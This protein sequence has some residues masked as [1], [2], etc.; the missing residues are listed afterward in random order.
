MTERYAWEYHLTYLKRLLAN[1]CTS[2]AGPVH[3]KTS[4]DGSLTVR[5]RL[6]PRKSTR[7]GI[8]RAMV[9]YVWNVELRW[10]NAR[11]APGNRWQLRRRRRCRA[12]VRQQR[13]TYDSGFCRTGANACLR[14]GPVQ[15]PFTAE[16]SEIIGENDAQGPATGRRRRRNARRVNKGKHRN[17]NHA[18]GFRK[19]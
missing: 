13:K 11:A 2:L 9:V 5:V 1:G 18:S 15:R 12:D 16:R 7:R 14:R 6:R 17:N 4:E 10:A 3:N 8:S 19:R